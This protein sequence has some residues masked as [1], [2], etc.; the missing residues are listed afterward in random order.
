MSYMKRLYEDICELID[1]SYDD[2]KIAA[3]LKIP[4]DMVKSAREMFQEVDE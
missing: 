3:E 2:A 1:K 4:E